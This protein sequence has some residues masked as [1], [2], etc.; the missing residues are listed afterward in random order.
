MR[1]TEMII[2]VHTVLRVV[3]VNPSAYDTPSVYIIT[4]NMLDCNQSNVILAR[5]SVNLPFRFYRAMH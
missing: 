4:T 2:T 3:S 5:F 1:V